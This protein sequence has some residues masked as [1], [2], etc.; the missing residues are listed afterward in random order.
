MGPGAVNSEPLGRDPAAA[1][2]EALGRIFGSSELPAQAWLDIISDELLSVITIRDEVAGGWVSIVET[3]G[4]MWVA[5]PEIGVAGYGDQEAREE[6]RARVHAILTS[7][8]HA[9][10]HLPAGNGLHVRARATSANGTGTTI[11]R[12]GDSAVAKRGTLSVTG[13]TLAAGVLKSIIE[14]GSGG[15]SVLTLCLEDRRG[16]AQTMAL[17][18]PLARAMFSAASRAVGERLVR[19]RARR[20]VLMERL[21]RAQQVVLPL[22]LEG[23]TES[24]IARVLE[25][26]HHTIHDHVRGIYKT[27]GVTSKMELLAIWNGQPHM[28]MRP[29]E[30]PDPMI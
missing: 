30:D 5:E 6:T 3:A 1:A 12:A 25:R 7:R 19:P 23:R 10:E 18:N 2:C 16:L 13:P 14:D 27:L 9:H 21:S 24:E 4:T 20:R 22:L 17:S 15:A 28:E 26:S 8:V 11:G 29:A